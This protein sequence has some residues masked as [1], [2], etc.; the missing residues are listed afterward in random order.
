MTNLQANDKFEGA[1]ENSQSSLKPSEKPA[2]DIVGPQDIPADIPNQVE[3]SRNSSNDLN[4]ENKKVSK[5]EEIEDSGNQNEPIVEFGEKN[6]TQDDQG[7]DKDD[8]SDQE[9]STTEK[10]GDNIAE[11]AES[12]KSE[13]INS[14]SPDGKEQKIDDSS[15]QEISATEKAGQKIAVEAESQKSETVDSDS[16]HANE[17]IKD[18]P[19]RDISN[20]DYADAEMNESS[21]EKDQVVEAEE[22]KEK[23]RDDTLEFNEDNVDYHLEA[24]KSAMS[25][26]F[27]PL[28]EDETFEKSKNYMLSFNQFYLKNLS[29]DLSA[30]DE[31]LRLSFKLLNYLIE[32][33]PENTRINR[34]LSTIAILSRNLDSELSENE[35]NIK[36]LLNMLYGN[37]LSPLVA[38]HTL[39]ALVNYAEVH[40]EI[41]DQNSALGII[42]SYL[43]KFLSNPDIQISALLVLRNM[44]VSETLHSKMRANMFTAILSSVSANSMDSR[45]CENAFWVMGNIVRTIGEEEDPNISSLLPMIKEAINLHIQDAS[46]I[47]AAC[48]LLFNLTFNN[49]YLRQVMR[50]MYEETMLKVYSTHKDQEE[51]QKW[52]TTIIQ[53]IR[54]IFT[55]G[56]AEAASQRHE[57]T[58]IMEGYMEIKNTGFSKKFKKRFFVLQPG[59]LF[60]CKSESDTEICREILLLDILEVRIGNDKSIFLKTSQNDLLLF[61][62]SEEQALDWLRNIKLCWKKAVNFINVNRNASAVSIILY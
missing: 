54:A 22:S 49:E 17:H 21:N 44:S 32:S 57:N 34:V 31:S 14:D 26:L 51:I 13:N 20:G 58:S 1:V 62:E 8:S 16:L 37:S 33:D 43:R 47:E 18:D 24:L 5:I 30:D 55:A 27:R 12:Q 59:R 61:C 52:S 60:Y 3:K 48:W 36:T 46:T 19:S 38:A 39:R 9:I 4:D 29:D 45:I 42:T 25:N 15:P 11:E 56:T 2:D 41:L 40:V 35:K 53:K 50:L 7:P 28:S 23:S 6:A 10:V